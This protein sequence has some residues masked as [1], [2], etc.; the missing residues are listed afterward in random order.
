MISRQGVRE[1]VI[2]VRYN[3]GGLIRYANQTATQT[4]GTHVQVKP[5][6]NTVLTNKT[7]IKMKPSPSAWSMV[8]NSSIWTVSLS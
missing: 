1:L 6:L 3:G 2:D 4:A 7:V 8:S 5:L